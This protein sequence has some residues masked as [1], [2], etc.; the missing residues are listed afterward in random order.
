MSANAA[1]LGVYKL[2]SLKSHKHNVFSR[3]EG[4]GGGGYSLRLSPYYAIN[5]VPTPDSEGM[6]EYGQA[7]TAPIHTRVSPFIYV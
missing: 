5:P 7:E 6:D 1:I 4:N 2:D 3:Y